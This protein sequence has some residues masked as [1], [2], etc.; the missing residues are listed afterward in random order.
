[1]KRKSA[2]VEER[3]ARAPDCR[4]NTLRDAPD[5]ALSLQ[6]ENARPQMM[7]QAGLHCDRKAHMA[8]SP[9]TGLGRANA[10]ES[11]GTT[12]ERTTRNIEEDPPTLTHRSR[13]PPTA[14]R[15]P[16]CV[17]L[18]ALSA[19]LA[20]GTLP[21]MDRANATASGGTTHERT[22]RTIEEDPPTL[23]HRSREP[24]TAHRS[25]SLVALCALSAALAA[26]T[27]PGMDRAN[28]T[29]SGG[30]TRER[31]T[32]LPASNP[33][34]PMPNSHTPPTAHVSAITAALC[35]LGGKASRLLYVPLTPS[36][37]VRPPIS[38]EPGCVE[39]AGDGLTS[40]ERSEKR[41][42]ST[43]AT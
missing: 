4:T 39:E 12:H 33:P 9:L 15:S 41:N 8:D 34:M 13:E 35:A 29:A 18:C 7:P 2:A 22:T 1:M 25:P 19:A 32:S 6:P 36:S 40:S 10:T 5:A 27:L 14:H 42:K 31:T 20:V 16:I 28:A 43:P 21:G 17:A 23:T 38:W 3:T 11:G 30:T 26:R 24:P 37:G